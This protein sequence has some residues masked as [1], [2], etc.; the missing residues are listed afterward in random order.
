LIKAER[1]IEVQYNYYPGE[2]E[3]HER[4][5]VVHHEVIRLLKEK[6]LILQS[7]SDI[8]D[9]AIKSWKD[10]KMEDVAANPEAYVTD[11]AEV[12]PKDNEGTV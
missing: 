6:I 4:D 8:S 12:T 1:G 2:K 5:K 10:K 9:Q 7:Q 3:G 11:E